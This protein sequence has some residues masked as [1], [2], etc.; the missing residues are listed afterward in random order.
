MKKIYAVILAA[1]TSS[2]LGFN[3]LT[4]R[5]DGKSVVVRAVEPFCFDGIDKIFVVTN[6]DVTGVERELAQTA[7]S[8]KVSLIYNENYRQGMSSSI[9]TALPS[10]ED[11]DAVFLHLGDKPFVRRELVSGMIGV[12]LSGNSRIIVPEYEGEKGH[13]VLIRIGPR[14]IEEMESL[15]GD[16]GLREIIDKHQEDMVFIEGDEGTIFDIDTVDAL[17][18]LRKRG[19]KVEES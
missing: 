12:Y 14:I 6:P 4:V 3:K 7:C 17:S 16:R 19:H 18:T 15:E 1:G 2:R 5:I 13:P 9:K 11:G 10:I 8:T